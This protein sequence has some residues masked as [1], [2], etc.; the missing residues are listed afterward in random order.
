MN[1]YMEKSGLSINYDLLMPFCLYKVLFIM[2]RT[3]GL[4]DFVKKEWE[5]RL[6]WIMNIDFR[7]NAMEG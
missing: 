5:R 7:N 2:K 3:L 6:N 1:A 4:P